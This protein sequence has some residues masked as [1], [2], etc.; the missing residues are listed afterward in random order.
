MR[1]PLQY[2]SLLGWLP[3]AEAPN[4]FRFDS[5]VNKYKLEQADGPPTSHT[6]ACLLQR[7]AP[8][9]PA[10][11]AHGRGCRVGQRVAGAGEAGVGRCGPVR[12][13]AGRVR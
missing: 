1:R 7:T 4:L 8:S 3:A 11:A 13:G 12:A 5:S 6:H 2:L 9:A 10:G